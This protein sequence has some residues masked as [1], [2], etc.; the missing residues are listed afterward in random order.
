MRAGNREEKERAVEEDWFLRHRYLVTSKFL[1]RSYI[2]VGLVQGV[3]FVIVFAFSLVD[4]E[5]SDIV[6]Y[7]FAFF[8]LIYLLCIFG[9]VFKIWKVR[10]A[11]YIKREFAG[12][13]RFPLFCSLCFFFPSS[14]SFLTSFFI[15]P[16]L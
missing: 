1:T 5:Q 10:D 15:F 7:I 16:S 2:V 8:T 3:L 6:T 11:F 13:L 4:K 12:I 9:L 14:S